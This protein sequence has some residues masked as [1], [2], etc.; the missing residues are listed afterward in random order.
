M[1][2]DREEVKKLMSDLDRCEM[3]YTCPHGRPTLVKFTLYEIEKC[4][5]G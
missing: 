5:N 1:H 2:I 3:P 4:L